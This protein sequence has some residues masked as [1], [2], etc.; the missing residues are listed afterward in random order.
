MASV[1]GITGSLPDSKV[2]VANMGP[3]W[4]LAAPGGPNVG[5]MN[6]AI[7]VVRGIRRSPMDSTRAG[8]VIHTFNVYFDVSMNNCR[9]NCR[10]AGKFKR[11]DTHPR[12][13]IIR[14]RICLMNVLTTT[15]VNI[16][17]KAKYCFSIWSKM[18]LMNFQ[19]MSNIHVCVY[20]QTDNEV[21]IPQ[22]LSL[23]CYGYCLFRPFLRISRS[24]QH[25]VCKLT[26]FW[27][28][29]PHREMHF[30]AMKS[31]IVVRCQCWIKL[32]TGGVNTKFTARKKSATRVNFVA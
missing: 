32:H 9:I 19:K 21:V 17:K 29:K 30:S 13:V 1:S 4:V 20:F 26:I 24:N 2:H 10:V 25:V 31:T 7:R 5:P 6:L 22:K 28:I 8:P 18:S 16:V 15:A 3:N 11:Q 14:Y 12:D 27:Q 23:S